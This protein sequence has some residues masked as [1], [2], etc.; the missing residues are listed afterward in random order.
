MVGDNDWSFQRNVVAAIDPQYVSLNRWYPS[1]AAG[2]GPASDYSLSSSSA[3]KGRGSGG[4]DPG[5]DVAELGR[6]TAGVVIP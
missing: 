6:R 5:A 3:Y 2:M 4:T 1:N